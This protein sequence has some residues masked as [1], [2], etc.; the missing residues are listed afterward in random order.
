MRADKHEMEQETASPALTA[1]IMP[2]PFSFQVV[3][4]VELAST[5]GKSRS[6][7]ERPAR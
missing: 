3:Y 2:D 6:V 5:L 1:S 4:P 7:T